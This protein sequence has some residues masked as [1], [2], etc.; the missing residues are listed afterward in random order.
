M[1]VRHRLPGRLWMP[2]PEGWMPLQSQAGW[3][4]SSL[5]WWGQPCPQQG[6]WDRLGLK[7]PF[8]PKPLYHSV[9]GGHLQ[10]MT[11]LPL[12]IISSGKFRTF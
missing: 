3:G 5:S 1:A 11:E 12:F 2:I 9:T 7:G 6:G 4:L 10:E 8:Q